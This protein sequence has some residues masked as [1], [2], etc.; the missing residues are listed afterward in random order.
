MSKAIK[1]KIIDLN[2]KVKEDIDL[3]GFIFSTDIKQEIVAKVIN[4]QLANKRQGSHKV[5]E[6]N[7]VVGSNAKIYK[8]K[9]TGRARHGSKKVVQ[10][11]GGGVVHGP[12][13]RSH[14]KKIPSKLKKQAIR[15]LLSSKLK[16]GKLKIIDKLELK[17]IKT[18]E[19]KNKF[20]KLG[21][22]SATFIEGTEINKN[23][24]LSTRNLKEIDL[25]S[26]KGL[27][28]YQIIK[29][30]I[31]IVSLSAVKEVVKRFGNE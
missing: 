26:V 16:E 28:A 12:K 6:R 25:L 10:F 27:N 17:N 18:K 21:I 8:Q 3:P 15:I 14:N 30:D 13:V 7:E 22:K 5:K 2:N 29:R 11:K 4:W 19:V 31:L 24:L 9:G 20:D 23:F 1:H